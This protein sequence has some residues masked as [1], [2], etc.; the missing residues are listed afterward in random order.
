MNKQKAKAITKRVRISP[1]KARFTAGIIRGLL[2]E[3]ALIQLKF[4][5]TKAS[6]FLEMTLKSAIANAIFKFNR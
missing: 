3:D 4:S 6:K 1:K 2:V 5:N